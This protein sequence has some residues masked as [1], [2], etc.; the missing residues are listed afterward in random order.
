M[1][2]N[3]RAPNFFAAAVGSLL[4]N[5]RLPSMVIGSP[6]QSVG[7]PDFS[8]SSTSVA[9]L[10]GPSVVGTLTPTNAPEGVYFV[11]VEASGSSGDDAGFA[12]ENG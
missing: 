3:A 8:L 5:V 2:R 7:G 11:L 4:L 10:W 6:G 1:I 12:V 9:T